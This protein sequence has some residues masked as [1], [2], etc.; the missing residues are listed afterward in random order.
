M[1]VTYTFLT[2]YLQAQQIVDDIKD[3]QRHIPSSA[4]APGVARHSPPREERGAVRG[5]I[6]LYEEEARRMGEC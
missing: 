1:G 3:A 4:G 6:E 2:G 5:H